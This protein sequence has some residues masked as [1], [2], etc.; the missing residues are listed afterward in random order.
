MDDSWIPLLVVGGIVTMVI[1]VSAAMVGRAAM[2]T[3]AR[4][5][6]AEA[7]ALYNEHYRELAEQ[8][9]ISQ[10]KAAAELARLTERVAAIEKLLRDVG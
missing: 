4:K 7:G 10:E 9:A 1:A 3:S 6:E 8:C 2:K 5:K